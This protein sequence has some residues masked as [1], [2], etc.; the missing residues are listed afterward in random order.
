MT[1]QFPFPVYGRVT[2]GLGLPI[3][4]E[5]NVWFYDTRPG[6]APIKIKCDSN[7]YYQANIQSKIQNY[8]MDCHIK[9]FYYNPTSPTVE[10]H[11]YFTVNKAD[12]VKEVNFRISEKYHITDSSS[13]SIEV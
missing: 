1:L 2:N 4:N 5:V 8:G 7:G 11:H 6:F 9:V 10:R 13:V 3:D 12:K